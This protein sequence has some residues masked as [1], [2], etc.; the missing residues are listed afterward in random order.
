MKLTHAPLV[1][2]LLSSAP[3]LAQM[4]DPTK[5]NLK[6]TPVAGNISLIEGADG[7]SGGNV[8]ISVGDDGAFVIDDAL[9]PLT[10]KL[11]AAA[12]TLTKKP[13][14]F[15][16]NTHWHHDHT[17]GNAALGGSGSILVAH[18]SVRKRLS[19]DQFLDFM[20][21][22]MTFPAQPPAALPVITFT[23]EVTLHL[24]GDDVH[25]MHVPPAHTD[26]DV[27]VHF[28]K[29]NV[30]HAGDVFTAGYP[31]V[32]MQSGGKFD[33]FITGADRLLALS[34][35]KT[36]IIPGHGPLMSR[37]DLLAWREMLGGVRA[38][39]AKL[40]LAKK[41]LEQ[42]KAAKPTASFD[43]KFGQGFI[44]PDMLVEEIYRTIDPKAPVH[45]AKK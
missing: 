33:G 9:M 11:R 1:A 12:A 14:R 45:A 20:G 30:L 27:I 16:V 44:K 15:I 22:K 5:V 38:S 42:I 43:A 32:D 41:T 35:D 3:A 39:V 25:A 28:P 17:G 19:V 37:A 40:M 21:N 34:D 6:V 10:A 23:D 31:L 36:R 2:L 13:I 4:G 7:F 18:E 8:G 26:G 29:A 24:N